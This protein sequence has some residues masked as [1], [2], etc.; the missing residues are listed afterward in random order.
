MH[1]RVEAWFGARG[2]RP[3]DFQREV[4]RA[5][6]SG[7]SGLIHAATGTGKTYAAW[8]GPLIESLNDTPVVRKARRR[9]DALPLRVLWI[10]PLRALAA[11][12][13]QALRLPVD[14]LGLPWTVESRTGD[15]S[16][17]RRARQRERLPTALV[18]TPESL[19]LLLCRKDSAALFADLRCVVVDEWHELLSTKRGAQVELALA[20]LRQL[21]PT[22]RTW[23]VSATLGNLDVA[24]QTLLG[25]T[26]TGAPRTPRLV[27]GIVPKDIEVEAL[28][29]ETMDRFPWAG[30]LN[31]KLLPEVMQ[32]LAQAESAIVF[33]NTRSQCE[34]W[35]QS[36][37]AANPSWFEFT[38]IH[39][40]SLSRAQREDVEDGLKSGRYRVV[41]ATSSLDLGVDFTPVD[42]VMQVGSPKGVARLLQ[43]AGR[44]GHSPGRVSRIVC[45]PTHAFELVEVAAARDAM[46]AG[47]IESRDPVDRPLDLLAQHLVTLALG[48]G[49]TRA[50]V[51]AEL[52][53]TRAYRDLTGDELDWVIDFVTRGGEALRAYPE[54]AKVVCV[55]GVYIV[56]DRRVALRHVLNIGT[57]VSDAAIAVRY[58]K[59]GR[60]GTVEE[61]F[62]SRLSPGDRFIFAGT[63]LEFVRLRDLTAWVRKAKGMS[64]AVPRWQGARM[65]L[66]TELA[67]AVRDKLEEARRGEYLSPEMRSVKPVLLMQAERSV[68]PRPDE[69][70]I[71][72]TET[73]DGHHL[74][75]YPF[76]GRL[77]HEGLAALC[78]YRMAQL[79]PFSFSFS[80]NDYGLE[81]LS[82]ERAPLEE[83]LEA[84]LF[85]IT[86]L[87]HDV[88]HSLNAAELAR[89]QF[90]EIARVAGLIFSG[91]PGQSKSVKQ[92]QAS[93]GLLYDVFVNYDPENLL[94]AQARREVLERQLEASRLGRV[95]DR[96]SRATIR[97]VDV[98]RPTPLAFPLMVDMTRAKLSTE[99]LADRVKRMTVAAEKPTKSGVM[100]VFRIDETVTKLMGPSGGER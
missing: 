64:G 93:S 85:S 23:G 14:E 47:A 41:V 36:I 39:H 73:R 27:R 88:T 80:C 61:S 37:I 92:L 46:R 74:F 53:T 79:Q 9:A 7:E 54:Y 40:G 78:A 2:W 15:T 22:L 100:S 34:I 20:R 69:L 55:D 98:E 12:T 72:R 21:R 52:R 19:S 84:G 75:V 5:Y 28:V 60:L 10:T 67:A 58:L 71:E 87:L 49:F 31:T 16:Q 59:G 1:D 13:E 24:A 42:L 66:S 91:Y 45:V 51:L 56:T 76:E 29:P 97:V 68:I 62:V 33:T 82:P 17:A 77:V 25:Y 70:L 81:L 99:K 32:R 90:R 30:H 6:A 43:R 50:G 86:H 83:A 48:G 63:P 18:T 96:L 4:W 57:I 11:D 35:F 44:S 65:P 38:A 94:V 95:L 89:R 26:N 3:F 8:M